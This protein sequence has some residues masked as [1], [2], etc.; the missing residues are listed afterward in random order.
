MLF[1]QFSL[2]QVIKFALTISI[3]TC[4]SGLDLHLEPKLVADEDITF[5]TMDNL[6]HQQSV[7]GYI[8][9]LGSLEH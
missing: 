7:N 4:L 2:D 8:F 1:K 6:F 9:T 3:L 5:I